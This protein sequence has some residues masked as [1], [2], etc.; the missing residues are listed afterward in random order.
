MNRLGLGLMCAVDHVD[1]DQGD[2]ATHPLP[3]G[4]NFVQ[5]WDRQKGSDHWLEDHGG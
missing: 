4:G 5:E 1:A 2:D 3:G